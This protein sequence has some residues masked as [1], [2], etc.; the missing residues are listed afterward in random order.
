MHPS[1]A[2]TPYGPPVPYGLLDTASARWRRRLAGPDSDERAHW[3]TRTWY[4]QAVAELFAEPTPGRFTWRDVVAAV[5]PRGSRSTFYDVAGRKAKHTLVEEM[6]GT[7]TSTATQLALCYL[8]TAAVDQL[9]DETKVWSYWPYRQGWLDQ[10]QPDSDPAAAESLVCVLTEWA[11][12][13]PGLAQAVGYAPPV[14][15]VEDLVLIRRGRISPNR[16]FGTL[17]GA[18]RAAAGPLGE[19][20]G[21]V[22][23]SVR[24]DLGTAPTRT[25]VPDTLLVGLAE[26]IYG[27]REELR[28]LRPEQAGTMRELAT[29]LVRDAAELLAE[30]PAEESGTDLRRLDADRPGAGRR[31]R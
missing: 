6:L 31:A 28:T 15:A 11:I 30:E 7:G 23:A 5:R 13:N 1:S 29:A 21:G 8:R 12:R 22:L 25:A 26:Q 17:T 27:L 10:L 3:R 9:V 20:P 2:A 18:L 4:Y 16:A 19:V 24:D 14:C